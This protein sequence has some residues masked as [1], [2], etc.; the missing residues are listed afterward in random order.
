MYYGLN[1]SLRERKKRTTRRQILQS[2]SSLLAEN[3]V[4]RISVEDI[5]AAAAVSRG[6]FFNYFG[7][8]EAAVMLLGE[9][10]GFRFQAMMA[11]LA[12]MMANGA[13]ESAVANALRGV[14]RIVDQERPLLQ[15]IGEGEV[16]RLW[17]RV[18]LSA[19]AGSREQRVL[20]QSVGLAV[21]MAEYRSEPLELE[22]M[23]KQLLAIAAG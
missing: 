23:A 11:G 1:M 20:M 22:T 16:A 8:K 21:V 18:D 7:S 9:G 12:K 17:L 15:A 3:P 10:V 5:V 4:S 2:L 14:S 19:M 13:D 6:T